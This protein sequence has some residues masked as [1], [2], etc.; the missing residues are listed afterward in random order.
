LP[1]EYREGFIEIRDT[2]DGEVVTIIEVLSPTNKTTA[3]EGQMQYGRKLREL[4]RT[5]ASIVEID[6]LRG[7]LPTAAADTEPNITVP[8]HDY[9]VSVS[10]GTNRSRYEVY[11]F[12]LREPLP[13][14]AI[15]LSP[16]DADIVLDLAALMNRVYDNGAFDLVIDYC[17]AP[18]LPPL[19]ESDARW[20]DAL[21]KEQG[22][23]LREA[24]TGETA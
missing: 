7:G 5:T 9:L 3:G 19:K 2:H 20:L 23:R 10:R 1:D 17:A 11:P 13:P 4:F 16:G 18:P 8:P 22:L 21:L 6:L 14:I 15:P 24:Q 12:T